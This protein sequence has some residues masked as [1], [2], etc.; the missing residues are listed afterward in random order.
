MDKFIE[1]ISQG[2]IN[3]MAIAQ[4]GNLKD[5]SEFLTTY[6]PNV[7]NDLMKLIDNNIKIDKLPNYK[8]ELYQF[9]NRKIS[10]PDFILGFWTTEQVDTKIGIEN[11]KVFRAIWAIQVTR[12]EISMKQYKNVINIDGVFTDEDRAFRSKGISTFMYQYL[13]NKL[14]FTILGDLE[15]YFGARKLWVGLSKVKSMQVDVIDLTKNK[16]IIEGAILIHGEKDEDF[17]KRIW[18]SEESSSYIAKNYRCILT[19]INL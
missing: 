19:K 10:E 18:D 6:K 8:L 13:V 3:E 2:K 16:I 7:V 15:Q 9:I 1:Y 4:K 14:Y 17:D 12:K 5:Y 11:K